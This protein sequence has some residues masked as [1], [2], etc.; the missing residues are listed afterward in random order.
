MPVSGFN[1]ATF[2]VSR[3]LVRGRTTIDSSRPLSEGEARTS[4]KPASSVSAV[5]CWT[6]VC[7]FIPAGRQL[8]TRIGSGER[9]KPN[10]AE[11]DIENENKPPAHHDRLGRL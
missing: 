5:T 4:S 9:Y 7:M 6:C 2:T 3:S 1:T 11:Y 8:V 10:K